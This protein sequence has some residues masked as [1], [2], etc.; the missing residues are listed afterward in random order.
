[1]NKTIFR[2][3][4]FDMP[5]SVPRSGLIG[6]IIL[7]VICTILALIFTN[8]TPLDA[9]IVG[10]LATSIHWFSDFIHQYGH[11][12]AAKQV[13][14]PATGLRVWWILGTTR[15]PEN[16]GQ[17]SPQTHAKRAIGGPVASAI[18]L[19]IFLIL[20]CFFGATGGAL[21]FLLA[22]GIFINF[23]VFFAGALTPVSIGW[24]STDGATLL[25]SWQQMREK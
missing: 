7:D 5:V 22:W 13:G 11:F 12:F 20:W 9:L 4:F 18:L 17:L 3:K 6:S 23:F 8:L 16:E 21:Q 2:F 25:Q 1:M 10:I 14:K 19:I 15:Y 24:F